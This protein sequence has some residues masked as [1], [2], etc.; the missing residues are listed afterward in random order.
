MW[1]S[2]EGLFVHIHMEERKREK[3]EKALFLSSYIQYNTIID[4]GLVFRL[5]AYYLP[6][7]SVLLALGLSVFLYFLAV[8]YLLG[9]LFLMC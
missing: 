1:G 2:K 4:N 8:L 5:D 7:S 3:R 6:T 9:V